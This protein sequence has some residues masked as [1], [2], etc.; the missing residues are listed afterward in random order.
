LKHI[1]KHCCRSHDFGLPVTSP[2]ISLVL[3]S[4]TRAAAMSRRMTCR[5][6]RTELCCRPA[7]A[8][9]LTRRHAS[10]LEYVSLPGHSRSSVSH[11]IVNRDPVEAR[12]Q[13]SERVK[14]AGEADS[15]SSTSSRETRHQ[16]AEY[17]PPRDSE[18]A[19]SSYTHHGTTYVTTLR[20]ASLMSKLLHLTP[21]LSLIGLPKTLVNSKT[22][23]RHEDLRDERFL[24]PQGE[25]RR[26]AI[27]GRILFAWRVGSNVPTTEPRKT[28]LRSTCH[29]VVLKTAIAY[30]RGL[31]LVHPFHGGNFHNA[32]HQ[33]SII[34]KYDSRSF[35]PPP[36]RTFLRAPR[37]LL[38]LFDEARLL[39][40]LTILMDV[41]DCL[42]YSNIEF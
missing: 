4:S 26:V 17:Y 41:I 30:F 35:I 2:M 7:C 23:S 34:E 20:P 19:L 9:L 40:A 18:L 36:R 32:G 42:V 21:A 12:K 8:S 5:F 22:C 1:R 14:K 24:R 31:D 37:F 10:L 3:F 15:S 28:V 16:S 38:V 25:F 27:A 39:Q 33:S 11:L 29:W 13:V 6:D